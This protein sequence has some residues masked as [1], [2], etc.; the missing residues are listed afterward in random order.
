MDDE[1]A[2]IRQRLADATTIAIV[3]LSAHPER[4]SHGVARYLQRQGYRVIPVNPAYAGSDIL[5]EVCYHSLDEAAAAL[6]SGHKSIDI[7]DLFRKSA[8]V[9]AA[10]DDAIAIGAPCVWLQLGIHHAAAIERAKGAGMLVVTDKCIKIE[11][12]QLFS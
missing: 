1:Q 8:E 11:H 5:G 7:V 6:K 2:L 10:I 3:G 4:P 9:G 12:M